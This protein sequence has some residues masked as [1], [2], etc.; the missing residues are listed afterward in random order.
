MTVRR[1]GGTTWLA[2]VALLVA[3]GAVGLVT[4]RVDE[5]GLGAVVELAGA[6]CEGHELRRTADDQ[7]SPLICTQGDGGWRWEMRPVDAP[8]RPVVVY[9]SDS[10][11]VESVPVTRFVLGDQ[12]DLVHRGYPG[13]ALCDWYDQVRQDLDVLR[14]DL[15]IAEFIGNES[16]PCLG[17]VDGDP[18]ALVD[19][20]RTDAR[21][22]ERLHVHAG[23]RLVWL[24]APRSLVERVARVQDGIEAA[25]AEGAVV[26]PLVEVADPG[27][28]L[29][30]G[31][32]EGVW[33]LPC[34]AWET[35]R[36]GCAGRTIAVRHIDGT[37]LCSGGDGD[38]CGEYAAGQF[39]YGAAVADVVI[40][41]L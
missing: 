21:E 17:D 14:P 28:V 35:V 4:S 30:D 10:L 32:G 16:R 34:A 27:A 19:R 13:S 7:G 31:D 39:R 3:L 5:P 23:V 20:Y 38:S 37:H 33:R 12:V 41:R 18:V 6:P 36:D 26:E 29:E 22:V 1:R 40:A 11:G 25:F 8:P 24:E 9:Y 15:V 2:L